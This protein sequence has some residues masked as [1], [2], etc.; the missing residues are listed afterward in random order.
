MIDE[1][2]RHH[3]IDIFYHMARTKPGNEKDVDPEISLVDSP[4]FTYDND[5]AL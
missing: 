4:T 5:S 3:H 2:E 1:I